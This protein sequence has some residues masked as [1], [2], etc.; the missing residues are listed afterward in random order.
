MSSSGGQVG[1]LAGVNTESGA[2]IES[3][4]AGTVESEG[5]FT[6]GGL[7]ADSV[8]DDASI[9]DS[10]ATGA[11]QTGDGAAGGL[12][13]E[14]AGSSI[15]DSYAA[16][17][18]TGNPAGGLVGVDDGG[19]VAESFWDEQA[20]EVTESAGGSG[21]QPGD[22]SSEETFPD[23]SFTTIWT[24]GEAPDGITRPILTWQEP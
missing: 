23:W 12:V 8:G 9:R 22:F 21:L 17:A 16:G 1:G 14:N 19:T 24:L 2:I 18:V 7:V 11:V 20:S 13:G 4:A 3:Y 5:N 10:Y 15:Q 6:A